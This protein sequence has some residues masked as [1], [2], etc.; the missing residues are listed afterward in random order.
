[1]LALVLALTFTPPAKPVAKPIPVFLGVSI[2]APA[3][4]KIIPVSLGKK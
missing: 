3:P 1:M 2:P 4:R